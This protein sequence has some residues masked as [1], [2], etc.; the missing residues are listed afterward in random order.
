V[1]VRL[2][3]LSGGAS[4]RNILIGAGLLVLVAVGV[5]L[6]T[7]DGGGS[8]SVALPPGH[9]R[10][11]VLG[12]PFT[13]AYPADFDAVEAEDLPAGFLAVV[14]LDP[15]AYIDVRLTEV[16]ELTDEEIEERLRASLPDGQQIVREGRAESEGGAS[17][18]TFEVRDDVDSPTQGRLSFV[19]VDG[20]TWEIGCQWRE[21]QRA[22][23]EAACDTAVR[24][25]DPV[26]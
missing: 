23:I 4:R 20:Q 12:V 13:F 16:D 9:E 14:G 2:T 7:R 24:T 8:T 19:R 6:L 21:A 10:L 1:T 3:R 25:F 26:G 17:F 11:A 5:W 15:L 22:E 18:L